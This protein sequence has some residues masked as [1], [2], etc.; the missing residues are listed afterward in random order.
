MSVAL[1]SRSKPVEICDELEAFL[2][3]L[4]YYAARYLRSDCDGTTIAIFL[5]EFFDTFGIDNGRYVCGS[6]KLYTIEKG[7]LSISQTRKLQFTGPMDDLFDTLLMWFQAHNFVTAYDRAQEE[8]SKPLPPSPPSTLT[9]ATTLP[10][11]DEDEEEDLNNSLD[12]S[13]TIVVPKKNLEPTP[14][15]RASAAMVQVHQYMLR[16]LI[17]MINRPDWRADRVPDKVPANI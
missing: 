16:H 1:L 17:D 8:K 4:I 15:Q 3:V 2:Y 7:L 5:D 10:P 13:V 9:M 6:V 12:E 11:L 14:E